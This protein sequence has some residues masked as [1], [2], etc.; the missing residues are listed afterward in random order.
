MLTLYMNLDGP[1]LFTSSSLVSIADAVAFDFGTN[2][3]AHFITALAGR[4]RMARIDTQSSRLC[5]RNGG[6][7]NG[8]TL[9]LV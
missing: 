7:R 3:F 6:D 4:F 9:I 8:A 2:S 5:I 1:V